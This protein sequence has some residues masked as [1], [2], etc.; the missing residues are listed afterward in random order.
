[1]ERGVVSWFDEVK[2]YGFIIP[3]IKKEGHKDIFVHKSNVET[4]DQILDKGDRVEFEYGEG[5]KGLEAKTVRVL[6]EG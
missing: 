3:D 6:E 2:G 4:E 1:M 5:P